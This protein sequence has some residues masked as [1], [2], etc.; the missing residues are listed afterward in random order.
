MT[1]PQD[2]IVRYESKY[3]VHASLL[4]ALRQ[5]VRRFCAPDRYSTGDPP[6][7]HVTTLQLDTPDLSCYRAKYDDAL[8]RFKLR[9]RT[10]DLA[11]APVSLEIKRK[12]GANVVKSRALIA[13]GDFG[14]GLMTDRPVALLRPGDRPA[15]AE[16]QRLLQETGAQPVVAIR[17]RR[18]A[19]QAV[20][21]NY[22]RVTFDTRLSYQPVRHW[23]LPR[24]EERWQAIDLAEA[25]GHPY[26]GSVVELK[27]S[28]TV[29]WWM[30]D[31]VVRFGLERQSVCKYTLA[32][33]RE[34]DFLPSGVPLVAY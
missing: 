16:F 13:A 17:Y 7:Y 23:R 18:E 33:D 30:Q 34:R 26:S 20:R 11:G 32:V 27:T 4:P 1:A 10:Y 8:S 6:T 21:E 19:W 9:C 25:A 22:A 5:Q 24:P 31:L 29:P 12:L 14:A 2:V 28:G 3:W 15:L